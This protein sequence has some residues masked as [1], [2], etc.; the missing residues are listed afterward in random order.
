[1]EVVMNEITSIEDEAEITVGMV[2]TPCYVYLYN[3]RIS[4]PHTNIILLAMAD[5]KFCFRFPRIRPCLAGAFCFCWHCLLPGHR[6]GVWFKHINHKLGT[7]L[8][9]NWCPVYSVCRQTR[10]GGQAQVISWFYPLGYGMLVWQ[11]VCP[12]KAL[13]DALRCHQWRRN[14]A[15]EQVTYLCEQH[16]DGS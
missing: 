3:L 11:E 7:F 10:L 2:K 15:S 12:G 13:S 6:N 4:Y 8:T 1:M 14:R 5:I 16:F 9:C